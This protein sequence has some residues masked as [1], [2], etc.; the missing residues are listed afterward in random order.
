MQST[1]Y[2]VIENGLF[3]VSPETLQAYKNAMQGKNTREYALK[4]EPSGLGLRE[5]DILRVA[6]KNIYPKEY[7]LSDNSKVYGKCFRAEIQRGDI[8]FYV[9]VPVKYFNFSAQTKKIEE[10]MTPEEKRGCFFSVDYN[11][12]K[13][14][15]YN[16]LGNLTPSEIVESL[17]IGQNEVQ[18]KLKDVKYYDIYREKEVEK[19]IPIFLI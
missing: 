2:N 13:N 11:E 10:S 3:I 8:K 1:N 7:T 6:A 14:S 12:Y 17:Y 4:F 19:T 16:K 5:S 15:I 18:I 9:D